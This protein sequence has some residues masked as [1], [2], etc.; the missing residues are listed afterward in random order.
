MSTEFEQGTENQPV[1]EKKKLTD[2]QLRMAQVAAGLLC[3]AGLIVSIYFSGRFSEENSILNYLFLAVFVVI[4]IGRRQVEKKFRIR[5]NLF[6]LALIVGIG[7]G[8]LAYLGIVFFPSDP[9]AIP[10]VLDDVYKILILVAVGLAILILGVGL[11][12]RRYFKRKAEGKE[13]PLRYPDPEEEPQV[14][15]EDEPVDEEDEKIST[16]SPL[17]RQI[18]EMTKELDDPENTDEKE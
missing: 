14:A 10:V 11:P 15:A 3:A 16:L 5:L 1:P 17:E 13:L 12:L 8:I 4:M 6:S 9:Y 2:K 18:M 7:T